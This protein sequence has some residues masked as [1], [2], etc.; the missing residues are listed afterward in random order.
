MISGKLAARTGGR[1]RGGRISGKQASTRRVESLTSRRGW[2]RECLSQVEEDAVRVLD[3]NVTL[4]SIFNCF[5]APSRAQFFS[6]V[7]SDGLPAF[8][9]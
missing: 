7:N 6:Q 4:P 1:G 2:M 5:R 3:F 9:S 8:S